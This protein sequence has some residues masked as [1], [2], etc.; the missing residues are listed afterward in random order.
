MREYLERNR[1]VIENLILAAILPWV[2]GAV[3]S[4]SF[5]VVGAYVSHMTGNVSRMGDEFASRHTSIVWGIGAVVGAFFLGAAT[6]TVL[7]ELSARR[8][9]ARYTSALTTEAVLLYVFTL[10]APLV[11]ASKTQ[12]TFGQFFLGAL[13]AFGMGMQNALVT[14]ISGAVVRTTH[15]TGVLT[16]LGIESVRLAF[17]SKDPNGPGRKVSAK[18]LGI[19][20]MLFASFVL[21]VFMGPAM[22]QSIGVLAMLVPASVLLVLIAFDFF[23]GIGTGPSG[24]VKI[25]GLLPEDT[26]G[27]YGLTDSERR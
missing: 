27:S 14:R 15:L 8:K 18:K 4:C 16:D 9:R 20:V 12:V 24:S 5:L 11:T 7:I 2:A 6:A 22:F 23:L 1:A 26:R 10:M 13:L 3:N 21:G 25:R 19:L 17:P